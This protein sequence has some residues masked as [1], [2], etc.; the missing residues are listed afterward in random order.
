MGLESEGQGQKPFQ[1]TW[2]C[3]YISQCSLGLEP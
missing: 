2:D 1:F 3:E